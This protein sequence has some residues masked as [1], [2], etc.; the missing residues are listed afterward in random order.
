MPFTSHR[1]VLG[2][3]ET[4]AYVIVCDVTRQCAVL[5]V[6]FTPEIVVRAVRERNLDVRYLICTPAHF[7]HAAAMRECRR[8]RRSV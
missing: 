6:G 1:F 7:D 8:A 3:F 5:D 2:P 4:N